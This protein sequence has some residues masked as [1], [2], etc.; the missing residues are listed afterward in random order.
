[1]RPVPRLRPGSGLTRAVGAAAGS[2][3]ALALLVC[4]CVFAA[5]AGPALSLH[6]RSQALHQITAKLDPTV[7]TVQIGA[8]WTNFVDSI[9]IFSGTSQN[10]AVADQDLSPSQ[11]ARA[12]QEIRSSLAGLPLPLG[13][14]SW[15]GLT[16]Q[17]GVVTSAVAPSAP[18]AG[19]PPKVEVLHRNSLTTNA[20]VTPGSNP[21][22]AQPAGTAAAATKAGDTVVK[23]IYAPLG[24]TDFGSYISQLSSSGADGLFAVERNNNEL[25]IFARLTDINVSL[26][27][28]R[29]CAHQ[30]TAGTGL[31]LPR[32]AL[33]G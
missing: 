5:M 29:A 16:A 2:T 8:N 13:P 26:P 7:K 23:T 1:V 18:V 14:G 21:A 9:L 22:G 32:G 6:A 20:S 17:P 31:T 30:R 4:G 27:L 11:L 24:T 3:L 33:A 28:V 25:Q 19:R 15:Y 12:N 10:T